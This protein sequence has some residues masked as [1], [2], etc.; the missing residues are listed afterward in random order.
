VNAMGEIAPP[1]A[2]PPIRDWLIGRAMNP[3][4]VSAEPIPAIP[5]IPYLTP[6]ATA[7]LVGP[8]GRGRSSLAEASLYDAARE[9]VDSAYLGCEVTEPEFHARSGHLAMLRGDVIDA[10]LKRDLALVRYLDLPDTIST[11]WERPNEWIEGVA[12][13]FRVVVIDPLSAVE[14]ALGLNFEQRNTDF[15][16]FYDRLIQ[17]LTRRGVGVLLIDNIGHAT[18]AKGRAKG[19]S[20]KQD[21]VDII[22][23]LG[24][25]PAGWRYA[26]T[27]S[28]AFAPRSSAAIG[29]CSPVSTRH[30]SW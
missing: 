27:R 19:A 11:A 12:E 26:L 28:A 24:L 3:D 9:S 13:M 10:A 7:L 25:S 2:L 6:G 22:L 5:G 17:P 4:A 18:E 21:R 16:A 8:T 20:A 29:G 30:W 15:V 23:P 1:R 14:S